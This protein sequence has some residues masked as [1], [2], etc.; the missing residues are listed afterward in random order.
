MQYISNRKPG[1][2][3]CAQPGDPP[4]HEYVFKI[5]LIVLG[6]AFALALLMPSTSFLSG[7][8]IP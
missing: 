8:S 5:Y 7:P 4:M 2:K 3:Q 6:L 1:R